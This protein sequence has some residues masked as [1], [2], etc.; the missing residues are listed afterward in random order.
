[1]SEKEIMIATHIGEAMSKMSEEQ[2]ERFLWFA[3]GV[4]AMAAAMR[5]PEV[6]PKA[7]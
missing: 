2:K 5:G 6:T 3:E 1:M 4:A 7:G